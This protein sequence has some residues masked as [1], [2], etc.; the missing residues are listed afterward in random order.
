MTTC[1]W[2]F[3]IYDQ[4]LLN[5]LYDPR[6]RPGMTK[7]E[8]DQLLPD[9]LPTVRTWVNKTNPPRD[10]SSRANSHAALAAPCHCGA[11]ERNLPDATSRAE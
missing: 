5:I 1:K 11:S 2:D 9:V 4:Y 6:V 3:D 8:V 7:S 10:A